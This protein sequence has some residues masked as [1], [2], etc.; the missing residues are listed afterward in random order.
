[1]SK[2]RKSRWARQIVLCA[3]LAVVTVGDSFI[4]QML[5]DAVQRSQWNRFGWLCYMPAG[6]RHP[7]I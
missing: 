3:V 6:E 2:V 4:I 5:M 7:S 1:M